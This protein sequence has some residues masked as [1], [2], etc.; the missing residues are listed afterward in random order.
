MRTTLLL[1]LAAMPAFAQ[2]APAVAPPAANDPPGAAI[3]GAPPA[4][5]APPPATAP[6]NPEDAL[7]AFD[8]TAAYLFDGAKYIRLDE[9][10]FVIASRYIVV[11][12][13]VIVKMPGVSS[14]SRVKRESHPF[15]LIGGSTKGGQLVHFSVDKSPKDP[16]RETRLVQEGTITPN[17]LTHFREEKLP[18]GWHKIIPSLQKSGEYAWFPFFSTAGSFAFDFG[19]D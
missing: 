2:S 9:S 15:L 14:D 18:S 19:V 11:S 7:P 13:L 6:A 8:K 1:S 4:A 17:D 3:A 16:H 12:V 10:Q 5:S